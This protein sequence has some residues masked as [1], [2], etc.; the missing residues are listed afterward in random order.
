[1][2]LTLIPI[3]TGA[4]GRIPK[5]LV[6]G[7]EEFEI[8]DGIETIQ[9]TVFVEISQNTEKSPGDLGR[10]ASYSDSSERLWRE[11]LAWRMIK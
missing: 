7:L 4:L 3:V 5:G 2:K 10:F 8:R 9:T 11:K 6:M 1:M